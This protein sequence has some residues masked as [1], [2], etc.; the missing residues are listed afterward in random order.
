MS[1]RTKPARLWFREDRGT[2]CI[3]HKGRTI[4]T[5]LGRDDVEAAQD[6]LRE[7]LGEKHQRS[8]GASDP[9]Q[10]PVADILAAYAEEVAEGSASQ[11]TIGYHMIPL[12]E[13]WGDDMASAIGPQSCRDYLDRRTHAVRN[14]IGRKVAPAT[15]ARELTTLRA[16]L[17]YAE[18]KERIKGAGYVPVLAKH[19]S[20][21]RWL[22]R[23]E[24]A[25]ALFGI[26]GWEK[27]QDGHLTRRHRPNY[28]LARFFLIALYTLSRHEVAASV[29]W[30][31]SPRFPSI[32]TDTGM[33]YRLGGTEI[34]TRKRKG[35][36]KIP[37]RLWAHCRRWRRVTSE[38]PV[39]F[40]GRVM[41]K[42]GD[43]FASAMARVGLDDVTPHIL[44]HT[45]VTW[46]MQGGRSG[47]RVDIEEIALYASTTVATLRE[48]YGHHQ[49]DYLESARQAFR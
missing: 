12:L 37:D 32:N 25:L 2:W 28:Y 10:V 44:K 34:E 22:T 43:G 49:P 33:M 14:T 16:A 18:K 1:R 36:L 46:M 47:K 8:W 41:I 21:E 4:G 23:Q 31:R 38:G 35:M 7:Y 42:V 6:R 30:M 24:A 9:G 13:M 48:T 17:K 26:L 5:G 3:V 40:R 20:R 45:G 11:R 29:R 19:Q 27:G 39:E 15:A